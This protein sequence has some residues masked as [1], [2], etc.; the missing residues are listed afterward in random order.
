MGT[1]QS[2]PQIT[3]GNSLE[4][5]DTLSNVATNKADVA[6]QKSANVD[7][8]DIYP[9]SIVTKTL[10]LAQSLSIGDGVRLTPDCVTATELASNSVT[11]DAL[12]CTNVSTTDLSFSGGSL[13]QYGITTLGSI[14]GG[15][16][17]VGSGG[18]TISND[19]GTSGMYIGGNEL[20]VKVGGFTKIS[21]DGATGTITASKFALTADS[22]STIDLRNATGYFSDG[23][24][25]GATTLGGI[26]STATTA[27]SN[28]STAL[29]TA[30]AAIQPGGG[31]AVDG[32]KYITHINTSTGVTIS[33]AAAGNTGQRTNIASA[34]MA[35]YDSSNRV[36]VQC[37]YS[38][39]VWVDNQSTSHSLNER[40]SLAYGGAEV[41]HL[42]GGVGSLVIASVA[43]ASPKGIDISAG[44]GAIGLSGDVTVASGKVIK[45]KHACQDGTAAK[46]DG[47]FHFYAATSSGGSPTTEHTVTFQD[48]LITSWAAV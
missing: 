38:N 19:G 40:L 48:G 15:A 24:V 36:V 45:A 39:G 28:A 18:V 12:N 30:Q 34:G 17:A 10:Q 2:M 33:T 46:A 22:G 41:G 11:T 31:V 42:Y 13:S 26:S 20:F 4:D 16:L 47:H 8:K 29:S 37:D 35:I 32:S 14:S 44:N 5:A 23:I 27:N 9:Q 25:V 6:A 3:T 21:I 1:G 43:G 7:G